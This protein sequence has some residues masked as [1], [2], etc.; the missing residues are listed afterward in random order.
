MASNFNTQRALSDLETRLLKG[1]QDLV[2][3]LK[4]LTEAFA[5]F[6][7]T[8]ERRMTIVEERTS[9]L[10]SHERWFGGILAT[11]TLSFI[12]F[13]LYQTAKKLGLVA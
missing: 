8:N 9:T 3:V 1:Q 5:A 13:V 2:T 4:G 11:N 6:Q 12:G 10:L 7:I